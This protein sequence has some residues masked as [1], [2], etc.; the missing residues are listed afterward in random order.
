M[1]LRFC[2]LYVFLLMIVMSW[3]GI[4]SLRESAPSWKPKSRPANHDSIIT[5]TE[6]NDIKMTCGTNGNPKPSIIWYKNG[7]L[8]DD[9]KRLQTKLHRYS[10]IMKEVTVEDKGDYQCIVTNV[11]GSLN[12]TFIVEVIK[13]TWPLDLEEPQ[14]TTVN[15]GEDAIFTCRPLNDPTATVKWVKRNQTGLQTSIGTTSDFLETGTKEMLVVRNVSLRDAG[16]YTCLVGNYF[17]I[18]QVDAWLNVIPRFTT[19]TTTTTTTP[20]TTT[21]TPTTT[22]TTPTT[23]TTT[24]TT[25]TTTP[26]TTTTKSTTTFWPEPTPYD[27]NEDFNEEKPHKKDKKKKKKNKKKKKKNKKKNKKNRNK[28]REIDNTYIEPDYGTIDEKNYIPD[29]STR[30]PDDWFR[31]NDRIRPEDPNQV[32]NNG[33]YPYGGDTGIHTDNKNGIDNID[34]REIEFYDGKSD[35]NTQLQDKDQQKAEEKDIDVWTIYIIVGSVAGG[36]LLIG[37]VAI[38][39]AL[40]CNRYEEDGYKHANV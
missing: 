4:L 16:H 11:H 8:F 26:T 19:T 9:K 35:E 28:N 31:R 32:D 33:L 6:G 25:T 30:A 24:P 12:F 34:N 40:C 1:D 21:T 14:N 18:K 20:T 17:G 29:M 38:V 37:V 36:V 13:L 22:T 2:D 10:L 39:V 15:E 7:R 3:T 23:T 5:K 27:W